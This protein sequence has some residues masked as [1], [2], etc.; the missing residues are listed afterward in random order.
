M[1]IK[2]IILLILSF[3]LC[4]SLIGCKDETVDETPTVSE[5]VQEIEVS[6]DITLKGNF[7]DIYDDI[8]GHDIE[9]FLATAIVNVRPEEYRN[10]DFPIITADDKNADLIFTLMGFKPEDTLEFAIST[11]NSNSRAY[12]VAIVKPNDVFFENVYLGMSNRIAD[13]QRSVSD[14]PDQVAVVDTCKF[15][16]VGEYLVLVICENSDKVFE[17][18]YKVMSSTDLSD[19]ESVAGFTEEERNSY[20]DKALEEE[21]SQIESGVGEVTVTPVEDPYPSEETNTSVETNTNVESD[22]SELEG[23]SSDTNSD[24]TIE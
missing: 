12:C 15:E 24:T 22:N 7:L 6:E 8:E 5:P 10:N 2:N 3:C 21:I 4:F 19:L 17:Q 20:Y 11:T 18:L 23:T 1:K 9:K 14:Y 16:Q 13:L